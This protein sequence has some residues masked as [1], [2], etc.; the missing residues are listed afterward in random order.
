MVSPC[1]EC[2]RLRLRVVEAASV[3]TQAAATWSETPAPLSD[4]MLSLLQLNVD[5]QHSAIVE[6]VRHV[7]AV[8]RPL[9]VI[10]QD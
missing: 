4:G 2:D 1:E 6:Y 5:V 9:R 7:Q 8:H 10:L 3:A